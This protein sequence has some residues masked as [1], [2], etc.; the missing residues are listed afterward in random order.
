MVAFSSKTMRRVWIHSV[1][2]P[3][4]SL[5]CI[6]WTTISFQPQFGFTSTHCGEDRATS[7]RIWG[8]VR[9]VGEEAVFQMVVIVVQMNGRVEKW[10]ARLRSLQHR[11][12]AKK[13]IL[14]CVKVYFWILSMNQQR[15]QHLKIVP[16]EMHKN[17]IGEYSCGC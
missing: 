3:H 14:G 15:R 7:R 9:L 17:P 1:P 2:A 13:P 6:V 11:V 10:Q 4:R 12:P 5:E 8:P 16:D